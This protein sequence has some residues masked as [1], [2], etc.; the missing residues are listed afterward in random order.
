MRSRFI[1]VFLILASVAT[2]GAEPL[3]RALII[4]GSD[5][6]TH[7][8][9][10]GK[11]TATLFLN[12]T[13]GSPEVALTGLTLEPGAKVPEHTHES[14][15]WLYILSGTASFVVSGETL[16][17]K[18]GDAIFIPKGAKHSAAV[19]ADTKVPLVALQ[20]YAPAGAEQRFTKG[21]KVELKK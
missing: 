2:T 10:D 7:R 20:V 8:I 19:A 14:G 12:A 11:G 13:N 15:E 16:T 1:P 4:H 17:A 5:A 9:A 21:P 3:S 6:P 18:D